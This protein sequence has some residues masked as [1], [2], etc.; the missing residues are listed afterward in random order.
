MAAG[1]VN[2][3]VDSGAN[4]RA[5]LRSLEGQTVDRSAPAVS[6]G[7]VSGD[8][9]V[10]LLATAILPA[11]YAYTGFKR[12]AVE[13]LAAAEKSGFTIES[14]LRARIQDMK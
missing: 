3:L 13:A 6:W 11:R 10:R 12:P 9:G 14:K 2:A 5:L 1:G 4:A 7:S 8:Y